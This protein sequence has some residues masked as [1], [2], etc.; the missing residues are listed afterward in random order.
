MAEKA[1]NLDRNYQSARKLLET[2]QL[3]YKNRAET[4]TKKGQDDKA[5]AA[6]KEVIKI[7]KRLG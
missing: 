3:A 6:Y 7:G 1:L 5:L 4:Y 2:I